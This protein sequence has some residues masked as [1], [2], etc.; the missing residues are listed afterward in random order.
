[1]VEAD[2]TGVGRD[3]FPDYWAGGQYR[4][5]SQSITVH[6]TGARPSGTRP[7]MMQVIVAWSAQRTNNGPALNDQVET[8]TFRP[9]GSDW[10]P[11][12]PQLLSP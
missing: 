7:G 10:Q 5:C 6:A 3:A 8:I 9:V 1:V 12:P 11:V 2:V 4:P